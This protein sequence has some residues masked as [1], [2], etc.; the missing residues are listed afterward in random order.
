MLG[1]SRANQG[2]LARDHLANERTF[3]SWVRTG[4]AFVGLGV[5]LTE[6]VDSQGESAE[7]LALALIGLGAVSTIAATVRYL[8]LARHLDRGEYVSSTVGPL[9]VAVATLAVAVG[10]LVFVL[11]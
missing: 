5:V 3:L 2:S 1:E 8:A 4:L 11:R 10:G 9:L 6:L 7:V